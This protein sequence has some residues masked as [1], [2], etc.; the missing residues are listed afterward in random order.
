MT[1]YLFRNINI[2]QALCKCIEPDSNMLLFL[3]IRSNK[4]KRF[5]T[6]YLNLHI[7]F[8]S[9]VYLHSFLIFERNKFVFLEFYDV[10]PR[11]KATLDP[12]FF[13]IL[14]FTVSKWSCGKV[15]F[16]QACVKDSVH[17]G[18]GCVSQHALG[19]TLLGQP[20]PW[21]DT[22]CPV[23]AEIRTPLL[24]ACW[25]TPLPLTTTAVDGTHTTGMHSCFPKWRSSLSS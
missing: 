11:F 10:F 3:D 15:M 4:L 14:V 8:E 18:V 16:S 12:S 1:T 6:I 7:V 20:F 25:D 22:H 13:F 19:Q 21:A 23:H 5:L 17:R 2:I 9:K 24:S